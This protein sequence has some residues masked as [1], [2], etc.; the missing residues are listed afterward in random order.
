V[1]GC[2]LAMSSITQIT[3]K[4]AVLKLR[5]HKASECKWSYTEM[6]YWVSI[7]IIWFIS[8]SNWAYNDC[9]NVQSTPHRSVKDFVCCN[10]D[11]PRSIHRD[12]YTMIIFTSVF[13][14]NDANDVATTSWKW[15]KLYHYHLPNMNVHRASMNSCLTLSGI[16]HGA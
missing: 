15:C 3:W 7:I 16:I 9:E 6:I 11:N 14:K 12:G 5:G 10:L 1:Q 4:A 2:A 13:H 8:Y